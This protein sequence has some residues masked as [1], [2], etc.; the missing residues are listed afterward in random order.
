MKRFVYR[1]LRFIANKSGSDKK[2]KFLRKQGMK[3]GEHCHL[4][5]MAFVAEPYLMELGDYVAIA[6]GSTFITHDASLWCFRDE[7]PIADL[8]G[9]V[10]IGN[11]VFIG[12]NCTIL[13]NTIIGNNSVIGAGSVVR[14]KFPD[15]SVIAGNPAK[16]IMDMNVYR[17]LCRQNPDRL[18]TEKMTDPEKKPH[19]IKHFAEKK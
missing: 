6:N 8:F 17:F 12:M 18:N 19:V 14:G 4:E 10:K 7:F 3:I 11:N 15:N 9:K 5:T 2:I 13:P 1:I 16:V